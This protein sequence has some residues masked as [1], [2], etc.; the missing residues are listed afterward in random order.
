MNERTFPFSFLLIVIF[1]IISSCESITEKSI[2]AEID[3]QGHRGAR[4]LKPENTLPAFEEAMKFGMSTIELDTV[5]TKDKQL[6]IHHDTELNPVICLDEKNEPVKKIKIS[7][8]EISEIKKLDCGTLKNPKF[9]EQQPVAGTR[10]S[11][12]GEFF[13]FV[14]EYEKKNK[15]TRKFQ[16]NIETKFPSSPKETDIEEFARLMVTEIEKAKMVERSTVQ[17]FNHKVLPI[18]LKLNP[19]LKTSALIEPNGI[20]GYINLRFFFRRT[21][22]TRAIEQAITAN[23]KIISP[24]Y[25]YVD[26]FFLKTAHEK[27]L[28]VIPWT[29]NDPEDMKRLLQ[30]GVD[31]IISDYPDRLKKVFEESLNAKKN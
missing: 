21:K 31:G 5:V 27:N 2:V 24:Y 12:L 3:L 15:L 17:S 8:L 6:L 22:Q 9:P 11:T 20:L 7:D 30:I 4:G 16:F 28:I 29:V 13:K 14:Q 10:L 23:A 19:K 1:V 26:E 25:E 18:V